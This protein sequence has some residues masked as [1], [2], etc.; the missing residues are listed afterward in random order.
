M[1]AF[2]K[3]GIRVIFDKIFIKIMIPRVLSRRGQGNLG[4]ALFS[5]GL[6]SNG[7]PPA[8]A[9]FD[10]TQHGLDGN[11]VLTNFTKMKG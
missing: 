1:S 7:K 11:F 3:A 2:G 8:L 10:P 4:R 6:P 9:P 5:T